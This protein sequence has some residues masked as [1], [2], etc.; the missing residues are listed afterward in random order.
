MEERANVVRGDVEERANVVRGDVYGLGCPKLHREP[1]PKPKHQLP[2]ERRGAGGAEELILDKYM[3]AAGHLFLPFLFV[4]QAFL[5]YYRRL[6]SF[7]AFDKFKE[8]N[9][10]I[11]IV[12]MA[13][14]G[15]ITN[16]T[17][18]GH[19]FELLIMLIG[20]II[21]YWWFIKKT[22]KRQDVRNP[23]YIVLI[24]AFV[25]IAIKVIWPAIYGMYI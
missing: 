2:A 9:W 14:G 10:F 13:I 17:F 21:A 3:Q 7:Y 25:A 15:Y 12:A 4:T 1:K 24:V 20:Y 8:G 11:G 16:Y 22:I 18:F 23:T 5:I 6:V 19:N